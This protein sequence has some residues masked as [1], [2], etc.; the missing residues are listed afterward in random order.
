MLAKVSADQ[1]DAPTPWSGWK[2][3]D[4]YSYRYAGDDPVN[5]SDP[6]GDAWCD[7]LPAGCGVLPGSRSHSAFLGNG[8][9]PYS[10]DQELLGAHGPTCASLGVGPFGT[11]QT[12]WNP[13]ARIW[14]S[15]P[16]DTTR[17]SSKAVAKVVNDLYGLYKSRGKCSMGAIQ[18]LNNVMDPFLG[19]ALGTAPGDSL[20]LT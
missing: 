5:E 18:C 1:L 6:S 16:S 7:F 4:V 3:H 15:L 9:T 17:T 20:E 14:Y 2:V 8:Y 13:I 19:D 10:V 11:C 12:V